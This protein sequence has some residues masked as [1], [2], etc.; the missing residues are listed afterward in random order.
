[1]LVA[2]QVADLLTW[3]RVFLCFALLWL[4]GTQG[5]I[6]LPIAIAML[7]ASW[8]SDSLDGPIARR[9]RIRYQ[10][11]VGD[12]DLEIDMAVGASVLGYMLLSGFI[13]PLY[14]IIYLVI[15]V[16]YFLRRGIPR[17]LGM[18]FQAP[19]Y[20]WFIV[21]SMRTA[22]VAG[23]WLIAWIAVAMVATWPK[24]PREMVPGFLGGLKHIFRND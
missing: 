7:I 21:V 9:S 4:G 10:T 2:K 23:W 11:W 6:G 19:C 1:M 5:E 14:G 8:T 17:S 12:H 15:W 20:G 22:P 3:F 13:L 16:A 24:F 18:L